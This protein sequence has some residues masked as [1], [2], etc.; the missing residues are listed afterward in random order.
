MA[1][2]SNGT[3]NAQLEQPTN[4]NPPQQTTTQPVHNPPPQQTQPFIRELKDSLD[5]LP[6]RLVNAL[7]EA[8]PQQQTTTQPAEKPAETSTTAARQDDTREGSGSTQRR[9]QTTQQTT[10]ARKSFA[11]WWFNT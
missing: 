11:E 4:S 5:A 7:R 6:E 8:L 10:P 3:G 2:D 9:S 1:D